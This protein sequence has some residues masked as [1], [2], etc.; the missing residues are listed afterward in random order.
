VASLV[1]FVRL[2][3]PLFL[4]GGIAGVGLG[5]A[6]AA[7]SGHRIALAT[8]LWVQVLVSALHLMVHYANDYFDREGDRD[9]RRTAWSGGSGVVI[10][11]GALAPRVALVAALV[12]A[13][14]GL[15]AALRFA[16]VG[17]MLVALLGVAIAIGAWMYSAPPLRLVARG[18]G[19]LDAAL[20]VAV[21]VPASA[22][23]AFA[24]RLD[25]LLLVA[26]QGPFLAMLVM[27]LCVELPD[28]AVDAAVGKRT[29]AVRLD[30]L[31][32]VVCLRLLAVL[33]V[34]ATGIALARAGGP[35]YLPA[36]AV[37][38]ACCAG[39]VAG[40]AT[41]A[42]VGGGRGLGRVAMFGV[43]LYATTATGLALAYGLAAGAR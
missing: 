25:P 6:L 11:G 39:G 30:A 32:A 14:I 33:A 41:R 21:L 28:A 10:A 36:F 35:F 24:G 22:Y 9:A 2:S 18:L 13:A 27:M 19:E 20:V 4:Y 7:W 12:C 42:A 40:A 15:G 3:R 34:V 1:A 29:W 5:A 17:N 31:Q 16:L 37:P 43:G 26:L 8:Y 23:A 38:A